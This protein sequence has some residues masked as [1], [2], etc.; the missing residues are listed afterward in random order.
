MTMDFDTIKEN[1][2][3]YI[4]ILNEMVEASYSVVVIFITDI[5]KNGSYVIYNDKSSDIIKDSFGLDDIY[6]GMFL[7]KI[8]SRKKQIQPNI[9][10]VLEGD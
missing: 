7:P 10:S 9:I 6:Q 4:K 5:I 1:I 2:N 8:V 3:E